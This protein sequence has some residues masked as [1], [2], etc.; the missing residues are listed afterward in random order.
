MI[1]PKRFV[2]IN[3]KYFSLYYRVIFIAQFMAKTINISWINQYSSIRVWLLWRYTKSQ[4]SIFFLYICDFD[5][6]RYIFRLQK[7]SIIS[8]RLFYTCIVSYDNYDYFQRITRISYY[9]FFIIFLKLD[10][11][12]YYRKFTFKT[13]DCNCNTKINE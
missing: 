13:H 9:W 12:V 3:F 4:L 10:F 7:F 1:I 5:R 6:V 8:S 11:N 2:V